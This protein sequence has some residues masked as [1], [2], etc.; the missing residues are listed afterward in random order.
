MFVGVV[1]QPLFVRTPAE[2]GRRHALFVEALHRP[3]VAEFVDFLGA[4]GDLGVAL[5]DVDHLRASELS[6]HVELLCVERLF[7]PLRSVAGLAV[8]EECGGNFG[9]TELD[10]VTDHA[11]VGTMLH[12]CRRAV[13]ATPA[14]DHATNRLVPHVQRA[15]GG[16]LRRHVVVGVPQLD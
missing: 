6:E 10:E 5:G 1:G 7:E 12:H 8:C 4:I 15:V 3:G 2:L 13:V 14:I 9:E 11:G 16:V